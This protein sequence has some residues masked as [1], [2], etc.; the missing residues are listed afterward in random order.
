MSLKVSSSLEIQHAEIVIQDEIGLG[1]FGIIVYQGLY[2]NQ[3]VAVKTINKK[4][5]EKQA[6]AMLQNA[7]KTLSRCR[8]KNI[9]QLI[10]A[11][12][13][14]PMLILAFA[15]QGTLRDL[16][17]NTKLKY[18]TLLPQR[19]MELLNGICD[20]MMMLHSRNVLHLDLKPENVLISADGTP[21]VSDFGLAIRTTSVQNKSTTGNRGTTQYKAPEHYAEEDSDGDSDGDSGD[22]DNSAHKKAATTYGKPADV[23]SFGILCWEM[24]SGEE[25][26]PNKTPGNIIAAHIR[27]LNGGKVKRPALEKILAE[28]VPVIEACWAQEPTSRP[29]FIEA[30]QMLDGVGIVAV[31]GALNVPGYWDI[32]IGHSRR[33]ADAVVLATEAATWFENHGMTVW[34][35]VRMGD[36][37][38]AAMK[39]GVKMSKYFLAVVSGPCVN[40][41]RPQDP[42]KDNAYFRRPFCVMELNCAVEHGK[43]IQPVLRIGNK[44]Q[45]GEFLALLDEPLW[46]SGSMKDVSSLKSL[47]DTDWI[48]LNRNDNEYW[49]LGMRKVC[50]ALDKGGAKMKALLE[51]AEQQQQPQKQN[52]GET[53]N[54]ATKS[55]TSTVDNTLTNNS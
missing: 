27:A 25:P 5:N 47:G 53:K 55:S 11:C 44:S 40:N 29:T 38:A 16:L 46:M 6:A 41:D 21:W 52:N 24:F 51:L 43:H 17:L 2:Q 50:R 34:L 14:P 32:F 49:D 13:T 35:D 28:M 9:V 8:H 3:K 20:G 10:G 18:D 15:S 23:Y 33:C 26:Y 36:K 37:S 22:D 31:K 42:P 7:V 30:K 19:K 45:I 4:S 54:S 48:E 12:T 39:E 1:S